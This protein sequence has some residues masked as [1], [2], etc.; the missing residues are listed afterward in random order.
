MKTTSLTQDRVKE[1]FSYDPVTGLL[2]RLVSVG[3]AKA[4]TVITGGRDRDG[5]MKIAI[6]R[7]THQVHRVVWL[8]M[9]GS[10]P[11]HQID[12]R[13]H[14]RSNNKWLNLREATVAQNTRNSKIRC[15]NSSG[16]KGV[17]WCKATKKWRGEVKHDGKRE[18]SYFDDLADAD[19][20][21]SKLREIRHL[22]F[23]CHK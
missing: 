9:T 23:S 15:T 11:I 4:G 8:Y 6:D 7:C 5:Y 22:E 13:D 20:F 10:L 17:Y 14:A 18:Y 21:V 16:V 3:T 12:H 19:R 1:L 2:T